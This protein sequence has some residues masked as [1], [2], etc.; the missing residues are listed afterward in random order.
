MEVSGFTIATKAHVNSQ[1]KGKYNDYG[2][3]RPIEI[4]RKVLENRNSKQG[5]IKW[6]KV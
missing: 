1:N 4:S 3:R 2:K 6:K 5:K